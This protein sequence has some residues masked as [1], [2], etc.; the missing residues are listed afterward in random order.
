MDKIL[1]NAKGYYEFIGTDE[2]DENKKSIL[3][4]LISME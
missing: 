3:L 2:K 1:D 4:G